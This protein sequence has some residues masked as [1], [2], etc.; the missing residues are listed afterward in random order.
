MA[1]GRIMR[2]RKN[3]KR[4]VLVAIAVICAIFLIVLGGVALYFNY[5]L[6]LIG[7]DQGD[8]SGN[9]LNNS[10]VTLDSTG[11][12]SDSTA[13]STIGQLDGMIHFML[14]GVDDRDGA[15]RGH[16]DTMVL[17]S[18]NTKTKK[19]IMTSFMRDL[20]VTIPHPQ[21]TYDFKMNQAY[22]DG[23]FD[24]LRDTVKFN[25]GVEIEDFIMVE[26][27]SF[28][29]MVDELGGVDIT[30]TEDEANYLNQNYVA[31]V[32]PGVNHLT[33]QIALA[34][35]RIRTSNLEDSDFNRVNR[36]QN[37]L[38]SIFQAYKSK[39]LLELLNV[40]E[41]LL[42]YL[43]VT[44]DKGEIVGYMAQLAPLLSGFQ[45]ETHRIPANKTWW[46]ERIDGKEVIRA[47]L[48]VNRQI[49]AD[50]LTP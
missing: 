7:T 37:V 6:G 23:G 29:A 30:L 2:K 20:W 32:T 21:G 40:T 1:L 10:L 17:C 15:T 26:F 49:L 45:I 3:A 12:T 9:N 28:A 46:F 4:A 38:S 25:F 43:T 41:E 50:L 5:L 22:Y 39:P 44:M 48:D 19:I 8:G 36:Q 33:G 11:A 24:L 35:S 13:A 47:D 42:P 18:I 16:S 31:G 14:V 34:Y 27:A